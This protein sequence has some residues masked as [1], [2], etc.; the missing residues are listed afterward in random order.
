M[1]STSCRLGI[2]QDAIDSAARESDLLRDV[3]RCPI[4]S[5]EAQHLLDLGIYRQLAATV[6]AV[7]FGLVDAYALALKHLSP[8][9]L[10]DA[11]ENGQ[12]QPARRGGRVDLLIKDAQ[13]DF[14][15]LQRLR[16]RQ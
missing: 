12:D 14:L 2:F 16:E 3:R 5:F 1:F 15:V 10:G 11:A 9:H 4:F 13:T 7:G 8:F 6:F